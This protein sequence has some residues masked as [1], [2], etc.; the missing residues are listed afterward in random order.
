LVTDAQLAAPLVDAT[1]FIVRHEYTPQAAMLPLA[2]LYK[3][4]KFPSL[5]VIYNGVK[6]SSSYGYGYGYGY[7]YYGESANS[8]IWSKLKGAFM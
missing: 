7:G 6:G 3:E 8:S 4:K 1:V 2:N 5:T